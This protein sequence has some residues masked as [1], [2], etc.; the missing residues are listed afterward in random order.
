MTTKQKDIAR[1]WVKALRSGDYKKST[2]FLRKAGK[3]QDGF[4]CLGVLCDLAVKAKVLD[5][6]TAVE[7]GGEYSYAGETGTL[8]K[9][10]QNWAGLVSRVGAGALVKNDIRY[11]LTELNDGTHSLYGS[12]F[13]VGRNQSFNQI[14]NLIEKHLETDAKRIAEDVNANILFVV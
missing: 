4:C 6:P 1:R 12:R 9:A 10:V 5:K 3:T 14:A 13:S 8:P 7:P 11:D 2:G